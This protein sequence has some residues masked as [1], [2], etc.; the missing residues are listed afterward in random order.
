M[1]TAQSK[2]QMAAAWYQRHRE[3]ILAEHKQEYWASRQR[4]HECC[5]VCGAVFPETV[6]ADAK[7]CSARCNRRAR[8]HARAAS[9]KRYYEQH[10]PALRSN[11]RQRRARKRVPLEPRPC[12][13]CGIPFTPK[14]WRRATCCSQRC[15]ARLRVR[16]PE[17][18][19]AKRR[20]QTAQRRA[21]L[22]SRICEWCGRSFK[23]LRRSR[24]RWCSDRC[25][26]AKWAKDH[27]EVASGNKHRRRARLHGVETESISPREVFVRDGWICQLCHQPTPQRLIGTRSP[28]RPTLDHIVPIAKGGAHT[29]Q[30]VQC[31]C[32]QCN[33]RKSAHVKGQFRLF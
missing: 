7:Y 14:R 2:A 8:T 25:V 27:P 18:D 4:L 16:Q 32:S 24:A 12:K 15:I 3:R 9:W 11:T 1:A 19:N 31:A 30:N 13:A 29:Y 28:Q 33:C 22:P 10:G 21:T 5:V 23:P 26:R 17:R 20:Q 6:R